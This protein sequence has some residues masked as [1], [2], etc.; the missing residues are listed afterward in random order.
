[1]TTTPCPGAPARPLRRARAA[2]GAAFFLQGLVFIPVTQRLP[3]I[4]RTWDLGELAVSGLLL[5]VVL[6]AGIGSAASELGA[7]RWTSAG[8]LR[9][10]CILTVIGLGTLG[11]IVATL[12]AIMA[13]GLP[14]RWALP[15]MLAHC[16]PVRV[17]GVGVG[18]GSVDAPL[19]AALAADGRR[20]RYTGVEP[21]APSAAD[22]AGFS[23]TSTRG[24]SARS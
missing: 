4:K 14:L 11:G 2:A 23:N 10:G 6:L 12:G 20:V 22:F 1:M 24:A 13:A 19:A 7:R 17:V 3:E 8:V 5:M 21:H 9:I 15:P 16:D 18:D